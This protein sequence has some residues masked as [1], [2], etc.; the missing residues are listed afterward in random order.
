MATNIKR[1]ISEWPGLSVVVTNPTAPVT[2]NP[3][4]VGAMTGIALTDEGEGGNAA[5]ETTVFFGDCVVSLLVD[6]DAATGIAY[7]ASLYYQD[8]AT[9]SPTTNINNNATTPEAFFGI[10][11]GTVS[12]NGTATIDVLHIAGKP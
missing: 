1:Y 8:T 2:G 3:V 10:A 7:G 5:T 4:R 9:G 6:D 11:L 12:T